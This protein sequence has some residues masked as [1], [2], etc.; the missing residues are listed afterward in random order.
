MLA[1][2]LSRIPGPLEVMDVRID[3]PGPRE[4]LV[5]VAASGLCH[6]DLHHMEGKYSCK[7]PTVLGHEAAGVV[8]AVGSEV[9]DFRPGDHVCACLSVF[10]G[11][12]EF[13]LTGR[14]ALCQAPEREESPERAPR[15]SLN[16]ERVYQFARLAAFAE[17]MLV[18]E[19]ALVKIRPDMPLDRAALIG[20]AVTTGIGAVANTARVPAGSTV[21]VLG[22]GGIGLSAIQGAALAGASR[23]IAV[24]TLAWKLELARDFGATDIVDASEEDTVERVKELTDGGVEYSFE[25]IGLKKTAEQAFAMLRRGGT[26]TLIGMIPEGQSVELPGPELIF[27]G[28]VVQGSNMG[29][30]RFRLDI[31]RY[32]DLYMNG[33]L[34]LDELVSARIGLDE[35]NEGYERLKRGEVA[36]SVIVFPDVG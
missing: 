16:G 10:C 35:V 8:E 25:A 22:C 26:A 1:A 21:A 18:H 28:K 36:R 31:P 4:V 9:T 13:C 32:V 34:K 23:V 11:G 19:H 24:D 15:L 17:Q 14:P 30:N 12:C 6:S 27:E 33:R 3:D 2:V 7:L 29:S 20:C 5:R